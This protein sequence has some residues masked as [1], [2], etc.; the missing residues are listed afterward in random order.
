MSTG[1]G[2]DTPSVRLWRL[3]QGGESPDLRRFLAEAGELA[4]AELASV[5][6]VDQE[7]RWR[8]SAPVSAEDYLRSY[9]ALVADP[10]LALVLVYGEYLLREELG[11]APVPAEYLERFPEY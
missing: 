4:P 11:E 10:E 3:W 1:G 8:A 9:P 6:R 2:S 5:L 7:A